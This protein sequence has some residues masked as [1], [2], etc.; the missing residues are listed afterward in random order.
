VLLPGLGGKGASWQPFLATAS[1][2]F[3][4]L[5]VELPGSRNGPPLA[6]PVT[7]A[8]LALRVLELLEHLGLDCTHI[9]GRSMGGMIAQ[10]L[11]LLDP[12]RVERMVLAST[13]AQVDRHL[14]EVFLLWARMAELG[15]P[16]EVRHRS[17]L[18]WC[19]GGASL[20][21]QRRVQLYL[22]SKGASE[23]PRDYALQARACAA[24]DALDRLGRL[25]MPVL[26]VAGA[27]DRLTPAPHSETLAK[28]I[29]RAELVTIP[30]AGHLPYLEAA[31]RFADAV[32]RFLSPN[33]E[34]SSCPN[35][36][37]CS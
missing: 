4:T 25:T 14:A 34:M 9:V 23:N 35:A 24:H 26:V 11:A 10:E 22:A 32:L 2:R 1:Q 30:G 36:S 17:S 16:A 15:V 8:E 29:P 37:R 27:D 13:T 20:A 5:T 21:D 19:L 33:E 28:A 7:I 31:D 6:G 3:H 12:G 18:L